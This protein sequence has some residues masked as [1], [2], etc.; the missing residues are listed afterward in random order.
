MHIIENAF[1]WSTDPKLIL[2]YCVKLW[3]GEVNEQ[4]LDANEVLD[5][6]LD[7]QDGPVKTL[8]LTETRTNQ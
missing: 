1:H 5:S 6:R 7:E 3:R 2:F 4:K 8:M